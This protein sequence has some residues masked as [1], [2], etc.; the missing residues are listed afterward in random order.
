MIH[1]L[2]YHYLYINIIYKYF[3]L[4]KKKKFPTENETHKDLQWEEKRKLTTKL[5]ENIIIQ[6]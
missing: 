3:F 5:D 6:V 2:K 4:L 1:L